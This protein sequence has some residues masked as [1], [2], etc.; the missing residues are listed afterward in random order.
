MLFR[1]G[2]TRSR[3]T[4]ARPTKLDAMTTGPR[5]VPSCWTIPPYL[6]NEN[7]GISTPAGAKRLHRGL[8][9]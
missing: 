5:G 2:R 3:R 9:I 1:G 6:E 4:M 8:L 7:M